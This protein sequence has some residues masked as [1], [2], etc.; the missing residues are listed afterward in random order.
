M[1]LVVRIKCTMKVNQLEMLN[2]GNGK[3]NLVELSVFI[4]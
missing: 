2:N 4:T 1:A 3:L